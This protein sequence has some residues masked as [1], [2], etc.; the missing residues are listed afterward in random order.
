MQ[1]IIIIITILLSFGWD[2]RNNVTRN[3][4]IQF[5]NAFQLPKKWKPWTKCEMTFD[6]FKWISR[7]SLN[8]ISNTNMLR[9]SILTIQT[10]TLFMKPSS[11]WK[12]GNKVSSF[13]EWW[14]WWWYGSSFFR[15]LTHELNNITSEKSSIIC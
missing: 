14:W 2:F 4:T 11:K 13:F 7:T 3:D 10:I 1:H 12:I 6:H 9:R 15:V 8:S 5:C